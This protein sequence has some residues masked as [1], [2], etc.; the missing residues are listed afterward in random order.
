MK[1]SGVSGKSLHRAWGFSLGV[2][3]K[4]GTLQRHREVKFH[5]L[6]E[7]SPFNHI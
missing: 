1:L 6:A 2:P 5:L 7:N 4:K 3:T